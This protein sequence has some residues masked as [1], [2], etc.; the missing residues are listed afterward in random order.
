MENLSSPDFAKSNYSKVTPPVK[1]LQ[2]E[3]FDDPSSPVKNLHIKL[4]PYR[5]VTNPLIE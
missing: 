5:Q 3:L 2:S 1:L 4:S